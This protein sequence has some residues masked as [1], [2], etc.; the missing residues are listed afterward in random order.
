MS[1]VFCAWV[2]KGGG[3][4]AAPP[5]GQEGRE[6]PRLPSGWEQQPAAPAQEGKS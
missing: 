2:V 4:T 1:M 5:P 6:A 3:V